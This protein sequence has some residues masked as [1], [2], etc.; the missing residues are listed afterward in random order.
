MC[1]PHHCRFTACSVTCP[2]LEEP[3]HVCGVQLS[4]CDFTFE[5]QISA[6]PPNSARVESPNATMS[7]AK[8]VVNDIRH[9]KWYRGEVMHATLEASVRGSEHER[10]DSILN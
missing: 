3:S 1:S 9:K 7:L 10:G 5:S 2:L 8:H 4:R 6:I